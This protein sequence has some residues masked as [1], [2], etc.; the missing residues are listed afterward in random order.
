MTTKPWSEWRVKLTETAS[1]L[2]SECVKA[3]DGLL[4]PFSC[5]IC[6][7][8]GQEEF[9]F[10][11]SCQQRLLREASAPACLRCASILG[12]TSRPAE[13]RARGCSRCRGKPLGFERAIALG[14]YLNGIRDLC[15]LMK[16]KEGLWLGHWM[17]DLWLQARGETLDALNLDPS[18]VIAA[19]IPLHWFRYACRGGNQ[20]EE[21]ARRLANRQR[22]T[23]GDPLR[24]VKATKPFWGLGRAERAAAIKQAFQVRRSWR[25]RLNGKTVVLTDDI[26]TTGA[27]L[28]A[29]AR[30]LKRGGAARVLAVVLGRAEGKF[31]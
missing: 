29:A 6:K 22:W 27:T 11:V 9:P 1:F 24:R 16:E 13:D 28:G 15:L 12:P 5:P 14:P 25:S 20:S 30:V 31:L 19:P 4:F 21:L 7:G 23:Y 10:C 3:F 8:M 18:Q 17:M 2:A 26:L